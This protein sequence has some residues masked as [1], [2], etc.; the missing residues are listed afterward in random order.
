M[1]PFR[2]T[3]LSDGSSDRVLLPILKWILAQCLASRPIDGEWA[4]LR[5]LARP[6]KDLRGKIRTAIDLYPCD[7]LF[8]HRDSE[9]EPA[10][11]R[12]E[13]IADG[14]KASGIPLPVVPVVTVR[15]QEAW[16][17][18]DEDAIRCAAGNPN[19][20]QPI[21]LPVLNRVESLPDPKEVLN[22]ILK[23]CSGLRGRRLRGFRPSSMAIHVADFIEDFSP[24]RAL[25][26]FQ[27]TEATVTALIRLHK[28]DQ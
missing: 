5:R 13:E 4:E 7:L 28:W 3:L 8:V 23:R 10:G 27:E 21:Q 14:V 20:K 9:G 24:L 18:F 1:N 6:P 26:A 19:G 15:M 16:L 22:G 17:L 11:K 12:Y 25:R 2:Y